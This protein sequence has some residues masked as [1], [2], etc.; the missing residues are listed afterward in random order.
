MLR[1][2][3]PPDFVHLILVPQEHPF[4]LEIPRQIA[5]TVCLYPLKYLRYIGWCVLGVVGNLV[6]ENGNAVKLNGEL[7]DRAVYQ[8]NIPG[9]NT[10]AHAV[11]IEVIRTQTHDTASETTSTREDFCER[12]LQRDHCCVWTGVSFGEGMHII[13][14]RRGSSWLQLIVRNRPHEEDLSS[15]LNINDIRN[16]FF[17]NPLIHTIF[18]RRY[19]VVLVT[20]NPILQPSDIPPRHQRDIEPDVSYPHQSRYTLQWIIAPGSESN[21]NQIPNNDDATFGSHRSHKPAD[22]LLHYTY[23]AAGV[24]HWGKNM[25]VLTQR[26]GISKPPKPASVPMGPTEEK[27]DHDNSFKKWEKRRR[28]DEEGEGEEGTAKELRT[29][30]L[31]AERNEGNTSAEMGIKSETSDI[32]D[33]D[34]VMLFFW[35]NTKVA[36]E[37]HA[38]EEEERRE[39]FEKWRSGVPTTY[40]HSKEARLQNID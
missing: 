21:L 10:L 40:S 16:G 5:T 20:P 6:D 12:L 9:G 37:R 1:P 24:K 14:F 30:R 38:R 18:D 27:H 29:K 4:Y 32:W 2:V 19:L 13:P 7:V 25:N 33:E 11:D 28:E 36:R 17:V 26:P 15:L 31:A 34:D 23:G 3:P 39:Y 22:L 35:G 8:Y